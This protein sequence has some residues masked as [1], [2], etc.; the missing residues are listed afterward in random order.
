[1]DKNRIK[2]AVK[3]TEGAIKES[4]GKLTGDASLEMKGKRR[5]EEGR[6]Q[7]AYGKAKDAIRES[8]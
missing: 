3:Q 4:T 5:K 8:Y 2:G 1:M 6:I 7:K